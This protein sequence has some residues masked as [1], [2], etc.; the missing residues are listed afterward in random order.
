[1]R[2]GRIV[3]LAFA[4]EAALF[5]TLVP[6]QKP[7]PLRTWFVAVTIG[8]VLLGYI[9]GRLA[10]RGLSSRAILHGLLVGVLATVI[11]IVLCAVAPGGIAAAI[12]LYGALLYVSLNALR[13]AGCVAG[14][15]HAKTGEIIRPATAAPR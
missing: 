9:A 2:W 14:A 6:L 12:A 7:L 4:L 10:A 15:M 13:I 1:M 3:G 8:C 5:V 11:Y